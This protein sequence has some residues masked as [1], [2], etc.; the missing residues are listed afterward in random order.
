MEFFIQ[1]LLIEWALGKKDKYNYWG[2]QIWLK[3]HTKIE[4]SRKGTTRV[5]KENV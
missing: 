3:I 1:S 4:R 2:M 5:G